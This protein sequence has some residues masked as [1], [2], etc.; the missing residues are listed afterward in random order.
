VTANTTLAAAW[1]V[2]GV[3]DTT[4]TLFIVK[5]AGNVPDCIE[6]IYGG[7]PL[8]T[9]ANGLKLRAVYN[10]PATLVVVPAVAT[11]GNITGSKLVE[12][13]SATDPVIVTDIEIFML[14][15]FQALCMLIW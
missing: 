4:P 13:A 3:P 6:Y 15:K 9:L 10:T 8:A 11:T 12:P 2:V 5:P 14:Y 1:I 7:F